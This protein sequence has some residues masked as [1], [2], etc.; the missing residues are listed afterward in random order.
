MLIIFDVNGIFRD[1][2][3]LLWNSYKFAFNKFNQD[4]S[5]SKEELMTLKLLPS[6]H[7]S[8]HF[9][10]AYL[11]ER[12]D[13][14][15]LINMSYED[16]DNLGYMLSRKIHKDSKRIKFNFKQYFLKEKSK[17]IPGERVLL[18][19]HLKQRH[20]LAILS[21][22][23]INGL[24]QDLNDIFHLFDIVLT[25]QYVSKK[26]H[27]EGIEYIIRKLGK[28]KDETIFIGDT[29]VDYHT[30]KNAGVKFIAVSNL[31]ANWFKEKNIKTIKT[32]KQLPNIL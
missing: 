30:A 21:N 8:L 4:F 1:V 27:P 3:D 31:N 26:P 13:L 25:P 14:A 23:H 32:I 6:L 20:N 24:K 15:R 28:T 29:F 22:S 16:A 7:S 9:I 5:L 10:N 12:K 18:L 17:Q 2:S 11:E 19:N